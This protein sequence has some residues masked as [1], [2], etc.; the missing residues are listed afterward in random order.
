MSIVV[1]IFGGALFL[2]LIGT[3]AIRRLAFRL[4]LI[5]VPRADRAHHE[6]TAMMGGVAI[7][8]GATVALLLG[9]VVASI[10]FQNWKNLSELAG[11]LAGATVM[12][13]VGLWDDRVR[14]KPLPKLLAQAVAVALPI[15]TGVYIQ[16]PVPLPL[17]II[18]TVIWVLYVTNGINFSDNMDGLAG[19]ISAVAAAFFTLIAAMN[20]QYLVS[21]L[22]A[23]VTGACLGFLR[24]NLPLPRAQ[25][26]MGD[27]GALF[28]GLVLA[29][30]GIKL[31]FPDNVHFVTWMVP[32]LVLGVPLFDTTMVFISRFRRN[33]SLMKGGIDHTSHRLARLGLGKLGATLALDLL[34]CAFGMIAIM[35]MQANVFEGYLI[36]VSTFLVCCYLLWN[37]DWRL[38]PTLRVG[39]VAQETAQK[40]NPGSPTLKP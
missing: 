21:A 28:L 39:E 11:I 17:N 36:G 31:R 22:A 26:F 1:A 2:A 32:V 33:V 25:I 23:A 30:L 18:L 15:L 5:S 24:Y 12:G 19:G 13:A 27:A 29:N 14:L 40:E 35:V 6:P 38:H 20:G 3:P 16:L 37:L 4:N 10:W 9:G 7:Y 34:G 8:L